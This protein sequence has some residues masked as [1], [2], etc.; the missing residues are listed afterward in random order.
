[1]LVLGRVVLFY[2]V[3]L[4]ALALLAPLLLDHHVRA[5]LGLLNDVQRPLPLLLILQALVGLVQ[6]VE[7]LLCSFPVVWV[8]V[9]MHQDG[10]PAVLLLDVFQWH[11]WVNLQHLEGVQV[12]VC[13]ARPQQPIDLL[14]GREN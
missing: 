2:C 10:E 1:M 13:R 7:G 8:L 5:T 12:E 6:H 11:L 14:F 9:W 3:P 4:A